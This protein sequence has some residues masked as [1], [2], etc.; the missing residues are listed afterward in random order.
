MRSAFL[1]FCMA[2][3]SLN[4]CGDSGPDGECWLGVDTLYVSGILVDGEASI[5]QAFSEYVAYVDSTDATF[6]ENATELVYISSTYWW[7]WEDT[8]YWLIRYRARLPAGN[9][10]LD[11][12]TLY[13]DEN[14][15]L[16]LP[17]GCI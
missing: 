15:V 17:R 14:G 5:Q 6:P 12:E 8:K 10:W 4:A 9:Q 3:L 1:I 16:V 2:L 13:I 11:R 7:R